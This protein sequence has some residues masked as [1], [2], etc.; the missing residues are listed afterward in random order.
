MT[1]QSFYGSSPPHSKKWGT[2]EPKFLTYLIPAQ[3][4]LKPELP[5]L[6]Q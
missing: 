4:T 1:R 5:Y 3:K 6:M 2:V